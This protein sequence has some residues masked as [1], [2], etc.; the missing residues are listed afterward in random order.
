MLDG[1]QEPVGQRKL[2]V[3]SLKESPRIIQALECL[4]GAGVTRA[5]MAGAGDELMVLDIELDVADA[6]GSLLDVY[7]AAGPRILPFRAVLDPLEL[8]Q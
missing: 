4:Q 6:A 2:R 1:A 8:F 5:G 3:L 7:F